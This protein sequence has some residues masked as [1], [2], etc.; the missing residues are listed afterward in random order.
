MSYR[1]VFFWLNNHSELKAYMCLDRDGDMDYGL[2]NYVCW[3]DVKLFAH[4]PD[5]FVVSIYF[6]L[7]VFT[8]HFFLFPE[9][10]C[11]FSFLDDH[12]FHCN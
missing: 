2:D 10:C 9:L 4:Y 11:I 1:S 5:P 6:F 12:P 3:A 8:E 7:F